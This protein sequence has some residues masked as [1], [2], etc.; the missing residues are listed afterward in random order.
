VESFFSDMHFSYVMQQ[1]SLILTVE[2]WKLNE[3]LDCWL[4]LKISVHFF[5]NNVILFLTFPVLKY[6]GVKKVL[7]IPEFPVQ[8][9]STTPQPALSVFSALKRATGVIEQPTS[10]PLE[11]G[12]LPDQRIS[13]SSVISQRIKRLEKQVKGRKKNKKR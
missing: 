9:P 12:K 4:L 5:V 3:E 11:S 8:P 1:C 6:P 2:D 7:G 13:S 10:V